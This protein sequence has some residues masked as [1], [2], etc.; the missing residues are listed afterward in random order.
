M[1]DK[2]LWTW[3]HSLIVFLGIVFF[4]FNFYHL[5][6]KKRL[7]GV[8]YCRWSPRFNIEFPWNWVVW[9]IILSYLGWTFYLIILKGPENPFDLGPLTIIFLGLSFY[10]TWHVFVG[11]EGIIIE[12]KIVLWKMVKEWNFIEKG[13]TKYLE[14]KWA[15]EGAPEKIRSTRIPVPSKNLKIV[16]DLLMKRL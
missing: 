8:I 15:Y 7:I 1:G 4:I 10:P 12:M 14:I 6:E 5:R 2:I 9:V 3:V 11:S 16:K 13:R